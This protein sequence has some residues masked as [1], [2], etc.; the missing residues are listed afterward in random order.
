M[1]LTEQGAA[2]PDLATAVQRAALAAGVLLI[3][4]GPEGNVIRVLPPLV[5]TDGELAHGLDVLEDAIS[6]ALAAG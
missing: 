1:N 2:R 3:T 4:S 6:N 5:I